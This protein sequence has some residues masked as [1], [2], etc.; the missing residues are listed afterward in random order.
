MGAS[1][2]NSGLCARVASVL[3]HGASPDLPRGDPI[4][5]SHCP[6][7]KVSPLALCCLSFEPFPQVEDG[8]GR[9]GEFEQTG[10]ADRTLDWLASAILFPGCHSSHFP[11][12]SVMKLITL[13]SNNP[14]N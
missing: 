1:D 11:G 3:T 14:C 5:S 13:F 10:T 8:R 6:L 4:L 7:C 9:G 12:L 2:S